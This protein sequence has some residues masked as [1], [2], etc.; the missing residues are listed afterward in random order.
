MLRM[1]QLLWLSQTMAVSESSDLLG[2]HQHPEISRFIENIEYG[3]FEN[4]AFNDE[5]AALTSDICL[6]V[7]KLYEAKDR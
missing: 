1:S 7:E 5:K 6:E 2:S 4:V 3:R